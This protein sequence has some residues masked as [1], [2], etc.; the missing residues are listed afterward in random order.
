[1]DDSNTSRPKPDLY[2]DILR[3]I[4]TGEFPPGHR[5][6]EEV[7]ALTYQVSRTPVREALLS[8]HKEGLIERSRHRG[9]RVVSFGPDDVEQIY[10]IR[11]ALEC[12]AVRKAAQRMRL[13][14]L[15]IL[16]RRLLIANQR[17]SENWQGEQAD[18]DLELHQMI[19][20][21]SGNRRLAR[22]LENVSSLI[23][24]LRLIGYRNDEYAHAAGEE[25]LAIVRALIR[26][27]ASLAERLLAAHINSSMQHVLESSFLSKN[28]A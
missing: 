26:R 13:G 18:I 23:H 20:S 9:A 22:Y 16:E 14:D 27:D 12:L 21:H 25:H 11:A 4:L 5:L 17:A 1:M 6:T 10:E 7:L 3:K 24:S 8:L 19:V 2:T 28:T 15:H